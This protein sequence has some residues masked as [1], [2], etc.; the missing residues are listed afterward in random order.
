[1]GIGHMLF[2]AVMIALG[3]RGLV[4]GD[5]ASVWQRIPIAD[6]PA[7]EFIAYACAFVELATGVGLLFKRTLAISS[8]IVTIYLLLWVILLKV[9]AIVA[10]PSMEATWLGF[11]EISL[12]LAGGWILF[13]THAGAWASSHMKFAVGANGV[14]NARILFALALPMIGLS[15]FVYAK[16]TVGFVPAWLPY[17]YGWAYLTGAGSLA[18]SLGVLFGVWP[19]LAS[20]MEAAMLSVITVLVWAP[21]M[22]GA[23]SNDTVTPFLM[24]SAIACG[25]WV[26]AD[27]YRGVAW[28]T[29]GGAARS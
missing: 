6:L 29:L 27:S 9:P 7:R 13:A 26:V 22:F 20:T 10:M 12:I 4:V 23:P 25:A 18:A 1:M 8:A 5:F 24:S 3:L 2:A 11:G 16:E 19:R 14:R 17:P 15:H 28:R 21:G